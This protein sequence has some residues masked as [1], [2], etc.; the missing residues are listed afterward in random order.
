[1]KTLQIPQ[2]LVYE[3]FYVHEIPAVYQKF[4]SWKT[5]KTKTCKLSNFDLNH[6]WFNNEWME[7]FPYIQT[8][9]D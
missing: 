1:M 4:T 3:K 9:I 7:I 5:C 6:S 8:A 2:K